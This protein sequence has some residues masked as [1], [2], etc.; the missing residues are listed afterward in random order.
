MENP[1]QR[2]GIH[3]LQIFVKDFPLEFSED[4][5]GW[6]PVVAFENYCWEFVLSSNWL[7]T[8][9]VRNQAVL[10]QNADMVDTRQC[11]MNSSCTCIRTSC[12]HCEHAQVC[13]AYTRETYATM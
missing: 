1:R 12:D 8:I 10:Q 7:V 11:V 4:P 9:G 6:L 2:G 5:P 3:D 13:I